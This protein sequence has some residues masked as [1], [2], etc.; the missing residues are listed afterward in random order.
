MTNTQKLSDLSKSD[1]AQKMY[2]Q[3]GYK[4][5]GPTGKI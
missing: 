5:M 4:K 3:I 2:S 1:G